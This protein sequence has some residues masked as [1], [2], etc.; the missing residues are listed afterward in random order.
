MKNLIVFR[1][2]KDLIQLQFLATFSTDA[3]TKPMTKARTQIWFDLDFGLGWPFVIAKF[4]LC[5]VDFESVSLV[6]RETRPSYC[7][8]INYE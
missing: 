2:I 4:K 3:K 8:R 6:R 7:H 1:Q 5:Y